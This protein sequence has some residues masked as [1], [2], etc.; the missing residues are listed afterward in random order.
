MEIVFLKAKKPLSKEISEEGVKPYPLIKN[1]SS[2]HYDISVDKKGFN[3][4]Y[5]LLTQQAAAGACLHK[6]LLKRPLNDE[7][8]AFMCDRTATTEL[9][10]I[11]IDGLPYKTGNV[12]IGTVAEQIVL[13]LPECFHNVSYIAQASASLGFKKNTVSMHLFFLLDMPVHPKTLKDFIRMV[14]Y[15][16]NFLAEQITLSANGQSLSYILDPS[17]TDNSKLIYIAPPTFVGVEDPYLNERFVKV[18]RG[19]PTLEIS[20]SL[21]GVNPEK[22]HTLGLQIKD[23]L[24]KK[25]NLPKRILRSPFFPILIN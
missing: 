22:V 9:L 6:G 10:V 23:N 2:E 15:D 18:D 19:S 11:D 1:F 21:I 14:N 20:S 16:S 4:L 5:K 7:P 8:R 3:K 17:V 25:N 13:Q 24:R 12:G